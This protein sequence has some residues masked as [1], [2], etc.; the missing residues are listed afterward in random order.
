MPSSSSTSN[1]TTSNETMEDNDEHA[2]LQQARKTKDYAENGRNA[3]AK[4]L[5]W[6]KHHAN[7]YRVFRKNG[8]SWDFKPDSWIT[9]MDKESG[10][11]RA[12]LFLITFST[13]ASNTMLAES[14]AWATSVM[15]APLFGIS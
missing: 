11:K 1:E 5:G 14:K 3:L 13:R 15:S 4:F 10:K 9:M 6:Y 2:E 7:D 8:T 12:M